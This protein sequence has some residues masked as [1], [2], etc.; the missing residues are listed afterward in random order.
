MDFLIQSAFLV[1]FG[2][3]AYSDFKKK[4]IPDVLTASMWCLLVLM[5]EPALFF[6][7]VYAFAALFMVNSLAALRGRPIFGWGDILIAPVYVALILSLLISFPVWMIITA[8][9]LP[10]LI[11]FLSGNHNKQEYVAMAPFMFLSYLLVLYSTYWVNI[12]A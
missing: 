12:G 4:L 5:L 1:L 10:L 7:V 11:G 2:I 9:M 6:F 8:L 3:A